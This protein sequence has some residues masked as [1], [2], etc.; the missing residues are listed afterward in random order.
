MES[1]EILRIIKSLVVDW[2]DL[3]VGGDEISAEQ[4]LTLIRRLVTHYRWEKLDE[5]QG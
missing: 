2:I 1:K 5:K 4:L 3:L